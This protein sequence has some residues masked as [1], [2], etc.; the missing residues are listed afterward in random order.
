MDIKE[1]LQRPVSHAAAIENP[2]EAALLI[3]KSWLKTL[4]A[5]YQIVFGIY[6]VKTQAVPNF[7]GSTTLI[8]SKNQT[9]RLSHFA[10]ICTYLREC[11]MK[12]EA[13][14]L[15]ACLAVHLIPQHSPATPALWA[16]S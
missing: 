14:T 7:T 6:C 4:T 10:C 9:S 8:G 1:D 15:V 2:E 16:G 11:V 13:F 5:G 3:L 12:T